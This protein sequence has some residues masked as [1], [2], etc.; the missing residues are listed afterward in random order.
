MTGTII[1][2]LLLASPA[3][4]CQCADECGCNP[5]CFCRVV[6]KCCKACLCDPGRPPFRQA[7][8]CVCGHCVTECLPHCSC[9]EQFKCRCY[10]TVDPGTFALAEMWKRR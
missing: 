9:R 6:P 4:R 3:V 8:F 1:A 2:A 7:T 5:L 10:A